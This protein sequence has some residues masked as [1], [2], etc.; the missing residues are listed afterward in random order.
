MIEV[1]MA[2]HGVKEVV[3]GPVLPLPVSSVTCLAEILATQAT[4]SHIPQGS[5]EIITLTQQ[6]FFLVFTVAAQ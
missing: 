1:V 4:V 5:T 2:T 3:S 6:I